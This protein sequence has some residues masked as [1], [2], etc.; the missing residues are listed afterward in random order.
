MI[1]G[2]FSMLGTRE[3]GIALIGAGGLIA[4]NLLI[5]LFL[6]TREPERDATIV[7][8]EAAGFELYCAKET[9][10]T[11]LFTRDEKVVIC[12]DWQW[13]CYRATG[14]GPMPELQR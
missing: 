13:R 4:I 6:P 7:A 2:M 11:V 3:G 12:R 14:C 1:G 10:A 8:R 9:V 5:S